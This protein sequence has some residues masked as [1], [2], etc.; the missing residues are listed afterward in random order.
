[1]K[2]YII[3][4]SAHDEDWTKHNSFRMSINILF[5][6]LDF[7]FHGLVS[8][9]CLTIHFTL[10]NVPKL[11]TAT[12]NPWYQRT[13]CVLIIII[14]SNFFAL[15]G[16][17]DQFESYNWSL[18]LAISSD[19]DFP[20]KEYKNKFDVLVAIAMQITSMY[21]SGCLIFWKE[22]YIISQSIRI[23]DVKYLFVPHPIETHCKTCKWYFQSM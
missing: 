4:L 22:K 19:A 13:F 20:K 15:C 18:K 16:S 11:K 6:K 7:M 21:K 17:A 9:Q 1:M 12:P 10:V 2:N 23:D 3:V 8:H 5:F 14:M